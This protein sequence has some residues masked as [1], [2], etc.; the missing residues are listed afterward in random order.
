[1]PT[2]LPS[3]IDAIK[4]SVAA[5]LHTTDA[6]AEDRFAELYISIAGA[7]ATSIGSTVRLA[8]P[9]QAKFEVHSIAH[10]FGR[11]TL[12]INEI[13]V[14][15]ANGDHD[16]VHEILHTLIEDDETTAATVLA[17]LARGAII[18]H[19]TVCPGAHA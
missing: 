16:N 9:H 6:A 13:I 5:L 17:H 14:A 19:R 15:A 1:M 10:R 11:D 8:S 3:H 7:L 18:T 4:A 12:V 2:D